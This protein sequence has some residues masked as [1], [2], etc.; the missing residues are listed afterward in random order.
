MAVSAWYNKGEAQVRGFLERRKVR[1]RNRHSNPRREMSF[2]EHLGELRGRLIICVLAILLTT[3]V[4]GILFANRTVNMLTRPFTRLNELTG[5]Q[6]LLRL[7]ILPD[8]SVRVMNLAA[9]L[10]KRVAPDR[11]KIEAEGTS[12]ALTI[13]KGAQDTLVALTLFAPLMLLFKAAIILGIIF[14][15]PIWLWQLWLFIAPA[16]TTRERRVIRPVLWAGIVLFPLG[17]VSAYGLL[18]LIMP[19]LLSYAKIFKNVQLMPDI[20]KYVSF[21]LS[22]MLAF[23]IIF[24][25]PLILLLAVRMG[26][27]STAALRKSRPFIAVGIFVVS[28]VITPTTDPV[29]MIAT[30]L[31]MILLFEIGLWISRV[32]ERKMEKAEEEE[33]AAAA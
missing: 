15:V 33:E 21:A 25:T 31:P 14:A 17:A 12:E 29:S 4:G 32:V 7:R 13:S 9:L 20:S 18:N 1:P 2:L 16:M 30:A 22:L 11:F 5:K 28:A 24:E 23:G 3:I 10:E 26:L 27:V 19:V 6:E 8:S